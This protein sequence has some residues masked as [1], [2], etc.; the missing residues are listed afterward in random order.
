MVEPGEE[1]HALLAHHQ[2]HRIQQFIELA[3]VIQIVEQFQSAVVRTVRTT[4]I[5]ILMAYR[6]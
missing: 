5:R 6:P 3:Q 1:F 4:S 2:E